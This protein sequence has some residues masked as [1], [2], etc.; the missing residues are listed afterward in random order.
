MSNKNLYI[1]KV[2]CA[3]LHDL[4]VKER[5]YKG[6]LVKRACM[7]LL[8]KSAEGPFDNYKTWQ[9][10]ER[11]HNPDIDYYKKKIDWDSGM[12][13]TSFGKMLRPFVEGNEHKDA[14]IT[15]LTQ[16][17]SP[18]RM[19]K[20]LE[21]NN[22]PTSWHDD[23][24][25]R[26]WKIRRG[27][28]GVQKQIA[29]ASAADDKAGW[30]QQLEDKKR[31]LEDLMQEGRDA[32]WADSKDKKH[33][34]SG[35]S[36]LFRPNLY[37]AY[38]LAYGGLH[39]PYSSSYLTDMMPIYDPEFT[40]YRGGHGAVNITNNYYYDPK[41][42]K[43]VK[44]D[45]ADTDA[46]ALATAPSVLDTKTLVDLITTGDPSVDLKTISSTTP[47]TPAVPAP[48]PAVVAPAPDEPTGTKNTRPDDGDFMKMW[49]TGA[50]ILQDTGT[51]FGLDME[52]MPYYTGG[53]REFL[54]EHPGLTAVLDATTRGVGNLFSGGS[55]GPKP[56]SGASTD[57]NLK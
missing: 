36:G 50:D 43:P 37:D 35:G 30:R 57:P 53:T 41:T 4:K 20:W 8:V 46:T 32:G 3:R 9:E 21:D 22:V 45:D 48:S 55:G 31:E 27:R 29:D 28:H 47:A 1:L 52:G 17:N 24:V 56:G 25:S 11:E 23:I 51:A 5:I 38:A 18:A 13:G 40:P 33:R 26:A 12:W 19:K 15:Y 49:G 34:G 44:K 54:K 7:H 6:A 2:A 16:F 42:G 39:S 14:Y 10:L